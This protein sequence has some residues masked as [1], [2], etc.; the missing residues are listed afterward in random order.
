MSLHK[1]TITPIVDAKVCLGIIVTL[2]VPAIIALSTVNIPQQVIAVSDNSS[3]FGYTWSLVLFII[4]IL[5]LARWF[6][7]HHDYAFQRKSFLI[8]VILLTL[9]GFGL[10]ILFAAKFFTFNNNYAHLPIMVPVVGGSVPIEEF[11]F[12]VTGF[13]ATL[14]LYIWCD[15]YWLGAYNVAD[16]KEAVSENS[17]AHVIKFHPFSLKIGLVLI[18]LG[19][20]FKLVFGGGGFPGYFVFLVS[21]SIVP[22]MLLL[23][24]VQTFIN[25]RALSFTFFLILLVSLLWEAT[26]AGP[27]QWWNYQSQRMLGIYIDAWT[28][29]PVEAVLVWMAVSYMTV[30]VYETIKIIVTLDKSWHQTLHPGISKF[31]VSDNQNNVTVESLFSP[32]EKDVLILFF[33]GLIS[34]VFYTH[35]SFILVILL[36]VTGLTFEYLTKFLWTYN[37][38][39]KNSRF[40][41]YGVNIILGAGWVGVLL[42]GAAFAKFLFIHFSIAYFFIALLFGIGVV[43]NMAEQLYYYLKLFSYNLDQ[44]LLAFPFKKVILIY[45]LPLSVRLGYFSTLPIVVYLLLKLTGNY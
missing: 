9:L 37:D 4:P 32:L 6:L 43:G 16:Y 17:I 1:K 24:T 5:I 28:N 39:I 34:N 11:I 2:L 42:L 31:F 21:C 25:W 14:L 12:Y 40:T 44:P 20:V 23:P 26:L 8:T 13:L 18:G 3:P 29:L 7:R 15:E 22:S 27:Y 10:D 45:H 41:I 33:A 36:Y 38:S 30:I 19:I 35:Y